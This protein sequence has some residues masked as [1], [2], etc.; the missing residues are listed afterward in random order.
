MGLYLEDR[1]N[2]I[3]LIYH[4]NKWRQKPTD[5][6]KWYQQSIWENPYAFTKI[7]NKKN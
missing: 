1:H 5:D 4:I 3:N 2:N 7:K 6:L